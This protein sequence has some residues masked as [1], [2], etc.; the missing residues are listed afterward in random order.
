MSAVTTSAT[1]DPFSDFD[2]AAGIG[3]VFDLHGPLAEARARAPVHETTVADLVDAPGLRNTE[4]L[5]PG[6]RRFVALSFETVTEILRDNQTWSSAAYA[7][8]FEP[9]AG[10]SIIL[11]DEP[12]HRR[13]RNLVQ[14]A[15]TPAAIECRRSSIESVVHQ[16]LDAIASAGRADLMGDFTF[17]YPIAVIGA[18]LGL[19]ETDLAQFHRWTIELTTVVAD[20]DTG[21]RASHTLRDYFAE[22][23]TRRRAKPADDLT[24]ALVEAELDG[25]HLT[26]EEIFAFLRTLLP[27]GAETTYRG[28]SNLLYA[29][30]T[31]PEQLA[32]VRADRRLV[33]AAVEEALRWE[34]S[35][36]LISRTAVHDTEVAGTAIPEG[37]RMAAVLTTANRDETRWARPE[38]FA[39]TREPLPSL[40]F[41]SG[42]H[43]CLGMHL[44]RFEMGIALDAVLDRLPALRLD[45][46]AAPRRMSGL[47]LRSPNG[48]PVRFETAS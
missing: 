8:F 47:L 34:S 4:A 15:F 39:I 3:V 37:S 5:L 11:M 13:Y 41:A 6:G 40:A 22:V 12:E 42:P 14:Q 2:R 38:N 43:M 19:P 1:R 30:L 17:R 29:L 33:P 46:D 27:A 9:V 45:P 20:A 35:P 21:M 25:E 7:D 28:T 44:A 24:T 26:D 32:A 16:H 36:T 18:V 10:R 31:H 48:L 23:V